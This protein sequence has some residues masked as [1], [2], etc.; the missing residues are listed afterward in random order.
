MPEKIRGTN[1]YFETNENAKT[2]VVRSEKILKLFGH[3]YLS[4]QIEISSR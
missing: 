2:I 4:F 3:N 1:I